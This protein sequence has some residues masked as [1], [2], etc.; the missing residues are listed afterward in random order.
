MGFFVRDVYWEVLLF[1]YFSTKFPEKRPIVSVS[2]NY[3]CFVVL[4]YMCD[5]MATTMW[6]L[7]TPKWYLATP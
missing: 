7:A 6:S 1:E 2:Q 5:P 3:P 4:G